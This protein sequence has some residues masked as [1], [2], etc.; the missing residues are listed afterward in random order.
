MHEIV[1][2]R[3]NG[4]VGELTHGAGGIAANLR[5]GVAQALLQGDRAVLR[6]GLADG[7]GDILPHRR[8]TVAHRV[9]KIF[10]GRR[11]LLFQTADA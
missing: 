2:H 3:T 7:P 11:S 10:Q 9:G 6:F 8:I 1:E 4:I 5:I